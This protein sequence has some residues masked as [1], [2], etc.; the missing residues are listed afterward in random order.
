ME[1]K[2]AE[3][4][5][6]PLLPSDIE[7]IKKFLASRAKAASNAMAAKLKNAV[8]FEGM[9]QIKQGTALRTAMEGAMSSLSQKELLTAIGNVI[10]E[11]FGF[12]RSSQAKD[13]ADEI[14]RVQYSALLDQNTCEACS[15]EDGDEWDYED[16]KTDEFAAGNRQCEG[17]GRCRC[18]L[19]YI[20]RSERRNPNG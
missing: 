17:R 16:P 10:P 20:S 19:V 12:G 14:G 15:K 4:W 2:M 18:L 7:M 11:G 13:M 8:V 1:T 5:P 6:E 9:G 3:P